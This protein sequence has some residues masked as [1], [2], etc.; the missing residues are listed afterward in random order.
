MTNFA[1]AFVRTRSWRIS[2]ALVIAL[3]AGWLGTELVRAQADTTDY[4]AL[5]AAA[6]RSDAD[7]QA[8]KRRDPLPFLAFVGLRPG[9]TALD[10][11]AG[12][13]YSTELDARA[14]AP[15]GTVYGQN[16]ADLLER[17]KAAFATRL[18]TP[19]MKNVIALTRPFDDPLPENVHDLDVITFL[20]AYHD[21]TFMKIDRAEMDRKLFAALRPG[22]I[23]VIADHAATAGS[24]ISVGKTLHRIDEAVLRREVEAAGFK[25]IAQGDFWRHPEDLRD[26]T[27]LK[28]TGPVDNFVLKFEK[29]K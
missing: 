13:G 16:P 22:G 28:P 1:L 27:T 23:L 18:A 29:P 8:D 4:A 17:P 21:T 19:A 9:M 20:F 14:V 15:T 11:G 6:D 5:L 26:F 24:D 3:G 10:M 12:A 25:L 7:R 2:A